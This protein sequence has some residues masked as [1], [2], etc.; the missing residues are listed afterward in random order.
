ME[1][2]PPDPASFGN[3]CASFAWFDRASSCWRTFQ[4]CFLDPTGWE[5][6][7]A[8]WPRAGSMLNGTVSQRKPSAPLTGA[9]GSSSSQHFATLT[10][11][12][13]QLSPSMMKHPGCRAIMLPTPTALD[14]SPTTGELYETGSGTVR[15]RRPDGR[16]S[17]IGLAATVRLGHDQPANGSLSPMWVEWLMG[18]PPGWTDCED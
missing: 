8:S 11:K 3:S 10:A 15:L 17:R 7:S 2:E 18:F 5:R 13:N 4:R 16:T 6:Y 14:W 12:A 1:S 9:T